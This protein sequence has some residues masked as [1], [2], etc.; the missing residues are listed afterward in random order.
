[1]YVRFQWSCVFPTTLQCVDASDTG[2]F[3]YYFFFA[4]Q[5]LRCH[6][7]NSST[8]TFVSVWQELPPLQQSCLPALSAVAEEHHSPT[9]RLNGRATPSPLAQPH[10]NPAFSQESHSDTSQITCSFFFPCRKA[11]QLPLRGVLGSVSWPDTTPQTDATGC[12]NSSI[13]DWPTS[14]SSWP[15]SPILTASRLAS[16]PTTYIG[17]IITHKGAC[18][19]D[20]M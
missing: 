2:R 5:V 15:H 18:R 1:M 3:F 17:I 13:A 19:M 11:S 10:P 7:C 9:S 12:T 16:Q 14:S 8:T 4:K 6:F 20:V